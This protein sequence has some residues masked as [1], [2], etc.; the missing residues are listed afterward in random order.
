[1]TSVLQPPDVALVLPGP[2]PLGAV[3]KQR[4]R[5]S[6]QLVQL[7]LERVGVVLHGAAERLSVLLNGGPTP[8]RLTPCSAAGLC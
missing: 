2:A 4:P 7:D 8:D 6:R 5:I 1:L 3:D